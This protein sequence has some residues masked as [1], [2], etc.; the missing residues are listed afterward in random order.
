MGYGKS[1]SKR[2]FIAVETY[3][4]NLKTKNISNKQ[5]DFTPKVTKRTNEAKN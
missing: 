3:L 5:P 4:K 1:S 2:M